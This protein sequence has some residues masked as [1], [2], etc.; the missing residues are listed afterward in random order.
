MSGKLSYEPKLVLDYMDS[1]EREHMEGLSKE[2]MEFLNK[3]KTE[4]EAVKEIQKTLYNAGLLEWDR[5]LTDGTGWFMNI[6]GKGLLAFRKGRGG[7]AKGLRVII[8]HIDSPRLDLKQR[9]LY[10]EA[11]MAFFKTHYYGGIKKY[12]WLSRPLALHGVIVKEDGSSI[13]LRIGEDESDPVFTVL[14]LLPHLARKSQYEKKLG[15]AIEG[16]KLNVL[17]GGIPAPKVFKEDK[18]PTESANKSRVKE[19]VLNLINQR[20]GIQEE[21]LI[22]SEIEVVPAGKA[23][24]VGFDKIFIGGYGQDDRVCAFCALKAFLEVEEPPQPLLVWFVDKEEI[25]SEGQSS[26]RC[27]VLPLAIR[28]ILL[29]QGLPSDL[30]DSVLF[31]SKAISGDVNAGLDPDYQEVHE[32]QNA[33]KA[34][35]GVVITKFTGHGGKV[36]ANDASAE[37]MGWIRNVFNKNNVIWQI[38]E[39]GKVDEG[40]GG[41]VSKYL[42]QYG[43]DIV[44][45]GPPLISMHSPF[46]IVHKG[47]V[48]MT[49]KGYKA[50]FE[51]H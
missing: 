24:E 20:Y 26:A 51:W 5:L 50:F 22:S 44:D 42:A 18:I 4:R 47:D 39:L 32:K 35:Y 34:G 30:A 3:A 2:Y 46:E 21:D 10:E 1:N 25:G 28:E 27:K 14:D 13:E 17:I 43:M 40:G 23:R 37:F 19:M 15:E 36:G 45:C 9:P 48:F 33:A 11:D 7:L 16:E 31:H 49:Y 29:K 12:Q 6:G 8:T 41:T 38:G